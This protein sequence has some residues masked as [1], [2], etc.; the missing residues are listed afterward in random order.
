VASLSKI[1]IQATLSKAAK[2]GKIQHLAN[3]GLPIGL[4]EP[5]YRK[6]ASQQSAIA[7]RNSINKL[8]HVASQVEHGFDSQ[9]LSRFEG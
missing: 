2:H 3:N 9:A 4:A 6:D 5:S 1:T 8:R 7:K